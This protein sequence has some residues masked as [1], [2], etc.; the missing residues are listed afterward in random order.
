MD[1]NATYYRLNKLY[2]SFVTSAGTKGRYYFMLDI[3]DDVARWS[4]EAVTDFALPG[5]FV[6]H[7][8]QLLQDILPPR[9]AEELVQDL[10]LIQQRRLEKKENT[11]SIRSK[12]GD[13]VPYSVRFFVIKDYA[14]APTYLAAAITSKGVEGNT[15]PTTSLPNQVRFL[16]H[17]RQLFA[18]GRR[19]VVLLLRA[20]NL[21]EINTLYGYTFGN[22]VMAALADH[23][24]DLAG[25]AGQLFRGEGS[26]L[27]FC[28]ET[29][30]ADEMRRLY[31]GQ[32]NY[33][34]HLLTIDDT[35]INI[36][37]CGGIVVADDPSV[38]V[39][40]ILVC[41]K[42]AGNRS[43]TEAGG[44]PII[45][46][47]DYLNNNG[48]TLELV[49]EIHRDV[50][51][52]C[53]HFALFYQPV[54]RLSDHTLAGSEAYLR[55][56]CASQGRISPGEFLRWLENDTSFSRLNNWIL[57]RAISEGRKMLDIQPDLVVTVNLA[58]RQLEQPE[59]HQ[60][61]LTL[62]KRENFPGKN[63]CLELTDQCRFLNPGFL[64]REV[65]YLKSCGIH[66]ALDGSCLLD[67]RLVRSLPVDIIKIG[68]D[69]SAQLKQSEKDRALLHALCTFA[70]ASNIQ[71]CAEGIADED[72]LRLIGDFA[73]DTYQGFVVSGA[74]PFAEFMK[75]PQMRR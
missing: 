30:T 32:K 26:M 37:L 8:S 12:S 74:V 6:H 71:V 16:E 68:R 60:Y 29:M 58:H 23:L 14:G 1:S 67:L 19:A 55:W 18:T 63:L 65:N 52:N 35:K 33:A 34:L 7:Q 39:H 50:L 62:L 59:F 56:D 66:V 72:M 11:W 44:E 73:V 5:E 10:D 15:D 38:D 17:L 75:L 20:T 2:D 4:P 31:I 28:S 47:N 57:E 3:H 22:R 27:L 69:F 24:K 48:K 42:F 21:N 43:E 64:A 40:A 36:K 54:L 70:K 51:N 46:Q 41:A 25:N 61:L 13:L 45:L 9:D 49:N 53:D